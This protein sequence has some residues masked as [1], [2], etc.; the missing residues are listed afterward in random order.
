MLHKCVLTI[1]NYEGLVGVKIDCYQI[2]MKHVQ[3]LQ[4][5]VPF[6]VREFFRHNGLYFQPIYFWHAKCSPLFI[7]RRPRCK[8]V[9]M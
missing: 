8:P 4:H 7:W 3:T 2:Y 1:I 6:H 9:A 5:C